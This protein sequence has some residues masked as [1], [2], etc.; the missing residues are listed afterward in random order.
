MKLSRA[1]LMLLAGC[2]SGCALELPPLLQDA[3][4]A[5]GNGDFCDLADAPNSQGY[6]VSPEL[7]QRLSAQFP[8]GTPE[9]RLTQEI[10]RQGFTVAPAP[11]PNNHA[12]RRA[13]IHVEDDRRYVEFNYDVDAEVYW[14]VD[15][16]RKITWV[17]GG[18]QFTGR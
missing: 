7:S 11:C 14:T 16:E 18:V 5:G 6:S 8:V 2:V 10:E 3:T 4:A 13:V 12:V 9:L 15:G 17:V 1:I